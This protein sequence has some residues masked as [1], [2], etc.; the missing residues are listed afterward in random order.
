MQGLY[1][2]SSP[3]PRAKSATENHL[4]ELQETWESKLYQRGREVCDCARRQ[5]IHGIWVNFPI[6]LQTS[7]KTLGKLPALCLSAHLQ[8]RNTSTSC[9]PLPPL[10]MCFFGADSWLWIACLTCISPKWSHGCLPGDFWFAGFFW[11]CC[12]VLYFLLFC[13]FP[14]RTLHCDVWGLLI[15]SNAKKEEKVACELLAVADL[16]EVSRDVCSSRRTNSFT[17][18]L[19]ERQ[20]AQLCANKLQGQG[21]VSNISIWKL[22]L[23]P[24]R[25]AEEM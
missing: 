17:E 19:H 7:C 14:V 9:L 13:C 10:D 21:K 1:N 8:Y 6:L 23:L 20:D 18:G 25:R 16:G 3:P 5:G 24:S 12:H 4:R 2:A 22:I 15:Y 11:V